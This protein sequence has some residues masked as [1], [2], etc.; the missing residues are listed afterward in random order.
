MTTD[1]TISLDDLVA[2]A[3]EIIRSDDCVVSI[4]QLLH[5]LGEKFG[6]RFSLSPDV[7]MV[8]WLI[9]ALWDDPHIDQVDDGLIEFAWNEEGYYPGSGSGSPLGIEGDVAPVANPP[10][11]NTSEEG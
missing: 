3:R 11:L 5:D 4:S 10:G 6:D 7:D 1:E 9:W 8:L 2:A